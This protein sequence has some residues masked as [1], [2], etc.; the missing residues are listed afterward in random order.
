MSTTAF[1]ED[2][3]EFFNLSLSTGEST[4]LKKIRDKIYHKHFLRG[5]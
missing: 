1:N 5:A 3:V 4:K 2:G